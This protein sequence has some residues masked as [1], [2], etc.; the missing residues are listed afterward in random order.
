MAADLGGS[1]GRSGSV[2]YS[3]LFRLIPAYSV[4]LGTLN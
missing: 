4:K 2:A 1:D 3:G